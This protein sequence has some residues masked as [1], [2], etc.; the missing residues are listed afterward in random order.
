M[1]TE[2]QELSIKNREQHLGPQTPQQIID[3][4]KEKLLLPRNNRVPES[5]HPVRKHS[6]KYFREMILHFR[7]EQIKNE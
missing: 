2:R 1:L 5:K 3:W 6:K 7:R 4:C